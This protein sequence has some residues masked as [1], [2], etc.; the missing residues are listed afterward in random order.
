MLRKVAGVEGASTSNECSPDD[1]SYDNGKGSTIKGVAIFGALMFFCFVLPLG[2]FFAFSS[3]APGI[4]VLL[5]GS[6][7]F[8]VRVKELSP[9]QQLSSHDLTVRVRAA[10]ASTVAP[11]Q[12]KHPLQQDPGL[13]AGPEHPA[14]SAPIGIVSVVNC[15][16]T[17]GPI[18]IAVHKAW[19]PRGAARFLDM[20]ESG[21]FNTQVA[22][23]RAVRN[24]LCQTGISGD[25][26][27]H[28]LWVEK[29]KINDDPQWLDQSVRGQM[30]RGYLSF[31]GGGTNSRSTE[32][33]FAFRDIALGGSPW[34]V[35]FGTLVGDESF[36]TMDHWYTGYG[37]L[38]PF[39]GKAPDQG[40]MYKS[41]MSYLKKN[42][43]EIDYI[44]ACNI[45]DKKPRMIAISGYKT[46]YVTL[47]QGSGMAVQKG[48][49]VTVHAT[50]VV[51]QSH[52]TTSKKFWSTKDP[53]Q[54]PF[55]Y[56]AGI[57]QVITG[58]DQG[59]LGMQKGEERK[60]I[61]PADEGYGAGGFPAWG[62]PPG[63]TLEFTLEVLN[64]E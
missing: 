3:T 34:E 9:L 54:Q 56:T 32:F 14:G 30:K 60:I 24:F 29:G 31:A 17:A 35:P 4:H 55:S 38:A 28:K 10:L 52:T 64:I 5:R 27:V 49:R 2:L 13:P 23:F 57:G 48:S 36:R 11:R 22:L 62:I 16:T 20:V 46:T 58:W 43:P 40:H 19:S 53:G 26:A 25:P 44:T 50:G 1:D 61:I 41:G 6:Q 7:D 51:Q 12:W 37:D 45:S 18:T 47:K 8:A 42:Y 15:E 59:L 63:A 39:G 33:F 21:F